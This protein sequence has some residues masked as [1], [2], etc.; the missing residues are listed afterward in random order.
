MDTIITDLGYALTAAAAL[1]PGQKI[2]SGPLAGHRVHT[3]SPQAGDRVY[4]STVHP[5]TGWHSTITAARRR[6]RTA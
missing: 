5:L 4:I 1:V 2:I 6:Y 3:V